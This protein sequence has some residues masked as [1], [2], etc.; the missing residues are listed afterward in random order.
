MSDQEYDPDHPETNPKGSSSSSRSAKAQRLK[1]DDK[2]IRNRTAQR[3]HQQRKKQKI[4]LLQEQVDRLTDLIEQRRLANRPTPS[5]DHSSSSSSSANKTM[6]LSNLLNTDEEEPP[7]GTSSTAAAAPVTPQP[8]LNFYDDP[9]ERALL[10]D[11]PPAA[12]RKIQNRIAQRKSR[13]LRQFQIDQLEMQVVQL[14]REYAALGPA[15]AAEEFT[16]PR[17]V[18]MRPRDVPVINLGIQSLV[19]EVEGDDSSYDGSPG[20]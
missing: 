12:R 5:R 16:G 4:T 13:A 19:D 18:A 8:Q 20:V 14:E 11:L 2:S 3:Q 1:D 17:P 9:E 7:A 15:P 10:K 6:S